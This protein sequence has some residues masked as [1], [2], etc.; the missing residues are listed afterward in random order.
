MGKFPTRAADKLRLIDDL[1]AGMRSNP[2]LFKGCPVTADSLK[3]A[4]AKVRAADAR[5]IEAK[6][7]GLSATAQRRQAG[8]EMDALMKQTIRHAE[9]LAQGNAGKLQSVGWSAPR[10]RGRPRTGRAPGQAQLLE[11][12]EEGRDWVSLRWQAPA[13]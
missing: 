5:K 1:V 13:D 11:I 8:Q 2:E 4:A 6:A 3:G 12:V 7:E 9:N 10:P